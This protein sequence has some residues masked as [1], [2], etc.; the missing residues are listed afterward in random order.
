MANKNNKITDWKKKKVAVYLRRSKGET[1]NTKK[2]FDRILKDL[3]RLEDEG[4]IAKLD[5]RIVGRDITAKKQ[6]RSDRDLILEGDIFNEGNGQSAFDNAQNRV[7]LN[8]LLRRMREGE[9]E[10]VIAESLDRYSRDPLDFS[11]V[12]LDLWRDN[13]KVFWGLKDNIGYGDGN[14]LSESIITSLLMWGGEGVRGAIDKSLDALE[15]KMNKGFISSRLKADLIGSG[16]KNAG[17]DYRKFWKIAQ[18]FGENE[19]GRL[20]SPSSVGK[21][22][23]R[24]HTWA[25]NNYQM[26]KQWNSFKLVDG[27]TALEAWLDTV[28]ALNQFIRERPFKSDKISFKQPEVVQLLKTSNGFINYPAGIN[29]SQKYKVGRS[30]FIQFPNPTDFDLDELSITKDPRTIPGW[31]VTRVPVMGMDLMKYQTQFRGAGG[32]GKR[33]V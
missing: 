13:A 2:Q 7:V 23:G 21:E 8:E 33:L 27:R 5:M 3:K 9:Y 19:K 32:K 15:E 22:F 1:G 30:Q 11:P 29:P 17:I 10:A 28:D 31:S 18:A 4:K 12:A 16:T 6:F 25:S 14:P 24:D 20:N 26:F